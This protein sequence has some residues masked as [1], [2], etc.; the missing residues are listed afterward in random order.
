[1]QFLL[2]QEKYFG[3]IVFV[4]AFLLYSNTI[5]NYYNMDDEL[6]TINHRNT[7]RGLS[8]ISDILSQYYYE[9]DMGYKYEYRPI[10]HLS[11]AIEHEFLG[12]S[13]HISH[14]IN[15]LLYAL[16]CLLLFVFLKN[17]FPKNLK[18]LAWI[19]TLL[20][21]F[22]PIHTEVVAS[23]KNRDEL[24]A[25]FFGLAG[26][27]IAIKAL[28]EKKIWWNIVAGGLFFLALLSKVIFFPFLILIP[29]GLILFKR[30]SFKNL[31]SVTIPFGFASFFSLELIFDN[32]KKLFLYFSL[33]LIILF[34]A[35]VNHK[36]LFHFIKTLPFNL[37]H[38][39][40]V[41][42]KHFF[43]KLKDNNSSEFEI[44]NNLK[45]YP[46]N[47]HVF[48]CLLFPILTLVNLKINLIE[49]VHLSVFYILL[50]LIAPNKKTLFFSTISVWFFIILNTAAFYELDDSF[51]SVIIAINL[52]SI[53]RI[54][55][56]KLISMSFIFSFSYI[57]FAFTFEFEDDFLGA[58]FTNV[59]LFFIW[60]SH[61]FQ[62]K[63]LKKSIFILLIFILSFNFLSGFLFKIFFIVVS[64]VFLFFVKI[65]FNK[66][67]YLFILITGCIYIFNVGIGLRTSNNAQ[68]REDNGVQKNI[69]SQK[70][71]EH[72]KN[73]T[74][75][76][77]FVESPV[78]AFSP[79]E[80]K[81]ATGSL[82][83]GK[84]IKKIIVPYPMGF[85]YGYAYISPQ[86]YNNIKVYFLTGLFVAISLLMLYTLIIK[87]YV[88]AFG[89]LIFLSTVF[90]VLGVFYPMPGAMG[91]RFLFTPSIGF[92]LIFAWFVLILKKKFGD[93]ISLSFLL[94]TIIVYSFI[95]IQRNFEWKDRKTLFKSDIE[96]LSESAQAQALLGYVYL[97][98]TK[99][100]LEISENVYIETLNKAK[101]QFE[102]AIQIYPNFENWWYDKGRIESKLGLLD[103]A[104][105]SLKKSISLKE[106]FLPDPYFNIANIYFYKEMYQDA[107]VYFKETINQ[108]FKEPVV[109]E[110]LAASYLN[111]NDFSEA[112][113]I[114][115]EAYFLHPNNYNINF[116]L[117]NVFFE[118]KDYEMAIFY[119]KQA[120]KIEPNQEALNLI[121]EIE[122]IQEN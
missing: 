25:V 29:I 87:N 53:L 50:L 63:K 21:V 11:F 65:L 54:E 76:L 74:R 89:L 52:L 86:K 60:L 46:P 27:H 82:I 68:F 32:D 100:G 17:L 110:F 96:Y 38:K 19:A 15:V 102:K 51:M 66:A 108:G 98:E 99:S 67:L 7:S 117:G 42:I 56:K 73:F 84:Y 106:G 26:G 61:T 120:N 45:F 92:V 2:K 8:A 30:L 57:L 121:S 88:I 72:N 113:N 112:K 94:I 115:L 39:A 107:I 95:T 14:A 34:F 3:L 16:V 104:L 114:L 83:F 49:Y 13:P 71:E 70:N 93:R 81:L 6:V 10:T 23:I 69:I 91:D 48:L 119:L 35:L 31:L 55:S 40:T 1:M 12:E 75:P 90:Q 33:T 111:L 43:E 28:R 20:F 47:L 18:L 36:Q 64:I 97:N 101:K 118:I 78:D 5:F 79:K 44:F 41:I 85:Y 122:L 59:I 103:E 62:N 105:I 37:K 9:D 58:I 4:A 109:F 22:H 80:E 24:L 77:N 116:T